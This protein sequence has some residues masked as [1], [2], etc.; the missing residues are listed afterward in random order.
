MTTGYF[1]PQ[2]ETEAS[3]DGAPPIELVDGENLVRL[4][5]E[6]ELGLKPIQSFE[7]DEQFF[8][9]FDGAPKPTVD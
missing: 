9:Q 3:R 5:G 1:T 7:V 2:A 6:L 4:L 8:G